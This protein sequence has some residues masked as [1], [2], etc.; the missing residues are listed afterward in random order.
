MRH[1]ILPRFGHTTKVPYSSLCA[2]KELSLSPPRFSLPTT[3]V[4]V[5]PYSSVHKERVIQIVLGVIHNFGGYLK[6]Q[7]LSKIIIRQGVTHSKNK[8][9]A[10][11]NDCTN[12]REK[13]QRIKVKI[14]F[15][16]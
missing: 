12:S 16:I 14:V 10:I 4:K 9:F 15:E 6:E 5:T 13:D 3:Q 2:H 8:E 7:H 1:T 11:K